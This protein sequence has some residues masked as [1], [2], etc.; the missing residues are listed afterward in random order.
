MLDLIRGI[1]SSGIKLKEKELYG[2]KIIP[3]LGG[4]Y[5]PNNFESTDIEVHFELC[6]QIH[7]QVKDLPTGTIVNRITM[8]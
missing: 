3:I 1:K 7:E 2:Y 4:Q 6:G 8:K 5:E